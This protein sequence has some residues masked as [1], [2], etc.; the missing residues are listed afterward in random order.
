MMFRFIMFL[1]G[2]TYAEEVNL[3]DFLIQ[4]R[5]SE[6]W[7]NSTQWVD[8]NLAEYHV[9]FVFSVRFLSQYVTARQWIQPQAA[10]TFEIAA[11]DIPKWSETS[12]YRRLYAYSFQSSHT[13]THL[14][15]DT[16][17]LCQSER[18]ERPWTYR[19]WSVQLSTSWC[20]SSI[21]RQYIQAIWAAGSCIPCIICII[22]S[23]L[24]SCTGHANALLDCTHQEW[25]FK[26]MQ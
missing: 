18:S 21:Y 3:F 20:M 1:V 7:R 19:F 8:F 13:H 6:T 5:P 25:F 24:P 26:Q 14:Y 15:E 12:R 4:R 9:S 11:D 2:R 22:V 23:I 16:V 10:L 17:N